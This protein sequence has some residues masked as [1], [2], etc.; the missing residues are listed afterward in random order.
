M[1]IP[2]E[3]VRQRSYEIWQQAGCPD[4]LSAQH[5]FQAKTELEGQYRAE[6]FTSIESEYRQTVSP[7]PAISYPPRKLT[8]LKLPPLDRSRAA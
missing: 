2:D 5:W 6:R 8:S 1:N 7:R 4:G 3:L